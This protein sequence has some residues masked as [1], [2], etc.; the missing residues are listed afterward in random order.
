MDPLDIDSSAFDPQKYITHFLK[1]RSIQE[2]IRKNNTVQQEIKNYDQE[3]QSL[4][5]QNYS[6]FIS[7]IDTVK[8][9]KSDI[10]KVDDKMKVLEESMNKITSLST[11]V[12]ESL[13]IKR[14]E[15]QKLNT[16]K[17]DLEKLNMLCR[18]PEILAEDLQAYK[19]MVEQGE[20]YYANIFNNSIEAYKECFKKLDEFQEE[21][22]IKPIYKDSIDKVEETRS[23]LWKIQNSYKP[24]TQL[25]SLLK[26]IQNQVGQINTSELRHV[27]NKLIQ[28]MQD[29]ESV[30][31]NYLKIIKDRFKQMTQDIINSSLTYSYTN[32][33][34]HHQ[35]F[36]Y[37]DKL[38]A[39]LKS[40]KYLVNMDELGTFFKQIQNEIVEME[41]GQ[42]GTIIWLVNQLI[43]KIFSELKV[44]LQFLLKELGDNIRYFSQ[45]DEIIEQTIREIFMYI[46]EEINTKMSKKITYIE[47]SEC[48]KLLNNCFT[49]IIFNNPYIKR[50]FKTSVSDKFSELVEKVC[51]GQ[52][53]N[54]FTNL[55]Q[56][57]LKLVISCKE[58]CLQIEQENIIPKIKNSFAEAES[59]TYKEIM[60]LTDVMKNK[61]D[62]MVQWTCLELKSFL[63]WDVQYLRTHDV[64]IGL[65]N[66]QIA[67]FAKLVFKIMTLRQNQVSVENLSL[68]NNL[69]TSQQQ[70]KETNPLF[71]DLL[72]NYK[73]A[74]ENTTY[75]IFANQ[76]LQIYE[77]KQINRIYEVLI[78]SNEQAVKSL[79]SVQHG[80]YEFYEQEISLIDGQ[81]IPR[82]KQECK[83]EHSLNYVN[84]VQALSEEV[85]LSLDQYFEDSNWTSSSNLAQPTEISQPILSLAE[86][87]R[88]ILLELDLF[89]PDAKRGLTKKGSFIK[90]DSD[91]NIE[92][93]RIL[94]KKSKVFDPSKLLFNRNSL[95]VCLLKAILKALIERVR[96]VKIYTKFGYQKLQCDLFF[97]VQI[98]YEM[99]SDDDENFVIASY[100]EMIESAKDNTLEVSSLEQNILDQI[101]ISKRT[102][103][104][105]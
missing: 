45:R 51:R 54:C 103:L 104:K 21:P 90:Q 7:S 77:N 48:F 32:N 13:S 38:E 53:L 96:K 25:V 6:R 63:Y 40:K 28:M 29:Q 10:F 65:I 8:K 81:V 64:F 94:V 24:Q 67:E 19:Q 4:V 71:T 73:A 41:V 58:Q 91:L 1:E 84:Y 66:I 92:V 46:L 17:V 52:V 61:L 101:S 44:E 16:I 9:M 43:N 79:F 82:L 59:F 70:L 85:L 97:I 11:K 74:P 33:Q 68:L 56:E 57:F 14:N 27:T 22:L 98:F 60:Y 80:L 75:F 23:V 105:L 89:F 76:F 49:D 99:I 34:N 35:D 3:I 5:F 20:I 78:Q 95:M 12:D 31:R 47:V 88:Q 87:V 37:S 2:L 42:E 18:F 72:K 36:N 62:C 50:N 100:Y 83:Y 69:A 39:F 102:Q 86:K 30:L 55:R 15:I 93:Q 26:P